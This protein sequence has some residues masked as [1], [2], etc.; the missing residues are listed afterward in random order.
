MGLR[1]HFSFVAGPD[2][3]ARDESKAMT[4]RRA[5]D[6]VGAD[7]AV[8]VGDRK[9]DVIGAHANGIPCVGVT[10]GI[11]SHEELEQA[12]ADVIIDDPLELGPTLRVMSRA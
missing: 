4:L 6:A 10:W 2:L 12:G 3:A 7:G 9:F 11:G 5:L 1:E 8:M